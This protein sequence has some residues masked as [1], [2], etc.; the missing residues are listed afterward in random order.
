[1]S[2]DV[3]ADKARY[4]P[5]DTAHVLVRS[6]FASATAVFTVEQGGLVERR[7]QRIDGAAGVFDV[8]ITRA[9]A[10]MVHATVTL[11]PIAPGG[12]TVADY[13]LG[14]VRI[15]VALEGARWRRA[16][17]TS[18]ATSSSSACGREVTK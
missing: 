6:P 11:L 14:A 15:P 4:V 8:P 13:R 10:P 16:P 1:M 3:V 7:T 17:R 9:H 2:I 5:G 18:V 12:E